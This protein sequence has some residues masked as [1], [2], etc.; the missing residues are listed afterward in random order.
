MRAKVLGP[1][2]LTCDPRYTETCAGA[3]RRDGEVTG[4]EV[5]T[6]GDEGDKT[7][8]GHRAL[9]L[10]VDRGQAQPEEDGRGHHGGQ[11]E[12]E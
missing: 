5:R 12:G 7:S 3:T 8:D 9:V 4:K 6:G 1:P 11:R 10:L 2:S